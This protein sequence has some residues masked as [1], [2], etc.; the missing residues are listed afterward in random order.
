M[1]LLTA[2]G[3]SSLAV[4]LLTRSIVLPATVSRVPGGEFAGA[5]GDTITIRVRQPRAAQVQATPGA[6]INFSQINETPVDVSLRHL[7]DAVHVTDEELSLQL[8]DF[9]RQVLEPQVRAIAIGGED[10]LATAMNNVVSDETLDTSQA[11]ATAQAEETDRVVKLA[12]ETL[13]AADVPSGNRFLACAPEVITLLLGVPKFVRADATGD[14]RSSAIRDAV[15]GRIYGFTVVE[16][17]GLTAS[18]AVAYH[19]SGFAFANRT[20]VV[21]RGVAGQSATS[22]EDG[23]GLRHIMQYQPANLQDQ[24]VVTTFAGANVVDA[25]R[26]FKF[27]AADVA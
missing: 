25:D 19:E 24:S 20:P 4:A 7:Y 9:G 17:N 26:V 6:A 2:Q 23:I 11:D 14:G 12:R 3:I 21:P 16:S 8:E 10:E 1:A 15:M 22:T 5:N 18:T 13:S 27:T